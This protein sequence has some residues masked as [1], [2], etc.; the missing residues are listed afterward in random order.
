LSYQ[1]TDQMRF[2]Y[3]YDYTISELNTF[4]SGS[5]EIMISYDFRF[6]KDAILSP[7]YF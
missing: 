3:S 7:R 4:S 6:K 1:V 2:G 5:H